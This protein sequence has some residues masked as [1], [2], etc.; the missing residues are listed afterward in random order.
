VDIARRLLDA[1]RAGHVRLTSA[2]TARLLHEGFIC[3]YYAER[4]LA[5]ELGSVLASLYHHGPDG[6]RR[7]I[8]AWQPLVEQNLRFV[9]IDLATAPAE[10]LGSWPDFAAPPA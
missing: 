4:P 10:D 8:D 5:A 3:A 2:E 9:G 1:V 7:A 6:F